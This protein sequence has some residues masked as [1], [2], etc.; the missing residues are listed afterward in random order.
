VAV[1]LEA[2][3]AEFSSSLPVGAATAFTACVAVWLRGAPA[4]VA[5]VCVVL[6]I[7][8]A[9]SAGF[10]LSVSV[11]VA[12]SSGSVAGAECGLDARL[13]LGCEA[14]A[15]CCIGFALGVDVDVAVCAGLGLSA[16][17]CGSLESMLS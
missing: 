9:V 10:R 2:T 14:L 16:I 17:L 3:S 15:T 4:A 13:S 7:G 8:A 11:C 6:R 5:A 12:L 1:A